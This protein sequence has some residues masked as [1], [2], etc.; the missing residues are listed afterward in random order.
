MRFDVVTLFPEFFAAFA[1][2]GVIGQ[3]LHNH[4]LELHVIN[5]RKFTSDVHQTV[6]DRPF[7][8]GDGMILKPEP[9]A[10]AIEAIHQDVPSDRRGP[11][12][13]LSAH[14]RTLDY[15]LVQE[16]A[17]APQITLVCGRYGGVDQRFINRYV[18]F[19]VSIGDFIMSGGELG[20]AVVIDSVARWI[21]QVLG[22]PDS[23]QNDSFY[24]GGL[25]HPLFTRPRDFNG[26]TVPATLASGDHKAI[27]LYQ[28]RAGIIKTRL[29]RP[30]LLQE[31][32]PDAIADAEA[33][34]R[35]LD[36]SERAVLGLDG[37]KDN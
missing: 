33:W 36:A 21:P 2:M 29:I 5:P 3:A 22:H 23:V 11:V 16:L 27:E 8:G 1:K 9:L 37:S 20:A 17:D 15:R 10:Q 26:Q 18:D 6:D 7:G 4:L 24:R 12:I 35:G 30:D 13:L 28:R 14:G 31:L 32:S 19:E 34:W 25:E